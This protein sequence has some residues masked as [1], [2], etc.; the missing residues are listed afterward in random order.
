M[1]KTIMISFIKSSEIDIPKV[2]SGTLMFTWKI[3]VIG[4]VSV[5][6]S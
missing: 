1:R 6:L 5:A 3:K 2:F 4:I